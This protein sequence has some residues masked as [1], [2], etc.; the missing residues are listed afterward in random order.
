[1]T[2]LVIDPTCSTCHGRGQVAVDDGDD[3]LEPCPACRLRSRYTTRYCDR[4]G[5]DRP[6]EGMLALKGEWN[7]TYH[8]CAACRAVAR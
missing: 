1:M 6:I 5:T 3:G 4:C 7:N 8:V 2:T